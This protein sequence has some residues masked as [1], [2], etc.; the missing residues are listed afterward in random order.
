LLTQPF[1]LSLSKDN[2]GFFSPN[3]ISKYNILILKGEKK[4]EHKG[5]IQCVKKSQDIY[6]PYVTYKK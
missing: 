6:H 3:L 5:E 4:R 1:I 2:T